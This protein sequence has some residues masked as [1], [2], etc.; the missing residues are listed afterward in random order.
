MDQESEGK[1][2]S[3]PSF[4]FMIPNERKGLPFVDGL[5]HGQ[6]QRFE[7]GHRLVKGHP[8]HHSFASL[9]RIPVSKARRVLDKGIAKHRLTI[10][11]CSAPVK[12]LRQGFRK[13]FPFEVVFCCD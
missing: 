4:A 5:H 6:Q 11:F 3:F 8:L 1:D 7:D 10:R 2:G 12:G 13:S 9:E